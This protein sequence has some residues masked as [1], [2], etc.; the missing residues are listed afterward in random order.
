[1]DVVYTALEPPE[2]SPNHDDA[3]ILSQAGGQHLLRGS[4]EST[5][6]IGVR[7]GDGLGRGRRSSHRVIRE[8]SPTYFDLKIADGG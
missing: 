1:M 3:D 2:G 7:R 4:V 6:Q 5:E 8:E